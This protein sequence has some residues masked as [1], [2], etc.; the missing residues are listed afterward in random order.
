[1]TAR[2]F[3]SMTSSLSNSPARPK[4]QRREVLFTNSLMAALETHRRATGIPVSEQVRRAVDEMV[5]ELQETPHAPIQ[6]TGEPLEVRVGIYFP[7]SLWDALWE[8]KERRGVQIRD[9]I[10]HAVSQWVEKR[11][12]AVGSV[13][14]AESQ[15]PFEEKTDAARQILEETLRDLDAKFAAAG[16][17]RGKDFRAGEAPRPNPLLGAQLIAFESS[18]SGSEMVSLKQL[19]AVPCGPWREAIDHAQTRYLPRDLA[20]IIG[21]REGDWLVPARGESMVEAG[22]PDNGLVVMRFLDGAEPLEGSIVLVSIERGDGRFDSTI[23]FWFHASTGRVHLANGK[24]E[25][26]PIP[27]DAEKV[28]AVA[29]LV[30]V[31]GRATM[32]T[33]TLKGRRELK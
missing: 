11:Q 29:V 7:E 5:S 27:E 32:G 12:L 33:G 17:V 26:F 4:K 19:D 30:G 24:M 1:M 31:M 6:R 2:G 9:L 14:L 21:A 20:E 18:S 25:P 3:S 13:E 23:K 8:I 10:L 28:I 16:I 22:V 15:E